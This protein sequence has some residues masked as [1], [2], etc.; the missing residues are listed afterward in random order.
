MHKHLNRD[1]RVALGALRRA[2]FNQSQIARELDIHR[3]TVSRELKRNRMASGK[4]HACN[5][6]NQA[7]ERRRSAKVAYRKIDTTLGTQLAAQLHPLNSPET[8]AHQCDIHH[9]TIYSWVY[10][11]RPDLVHK[12]PPTG[13]QTASLW[14]QTSQET[15]LDATRAVDS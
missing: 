3:S 5:A 2:G 11:D 7:R 9:Q 8:L 6:H 14:L 4:Y 12:L 1:A 10:R 15:R 13:S